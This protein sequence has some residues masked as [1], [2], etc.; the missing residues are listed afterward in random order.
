M[1][2]DLGFFSGV[3]WFPRRELL[4]TK[5]SSSALRVAGAVL[6]CTLLHCTSLE[7]FFLLSF[8]LFFFFSFDG[9]LVWKL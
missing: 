2:Y 6:A 9:V 4:A 3:F 8:C 5:G 7:P 1:Y